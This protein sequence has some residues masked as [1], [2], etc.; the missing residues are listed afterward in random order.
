[1]LATIGRLYMGLIKGLAALA[2][3]LILFSVGLV[4]FSVI[5]RY[6]QLGGVQ[7]T[8]ATVEYILLY[9]TMFSA[10]YLLHTQGHVMVDMVVKNLRGFPRRALE[11]AIYIIG[12][13]VCSTFAVVSVQIMRQAIERGYFDERSVD[14][15]Y[16]LLYAAYPLCFGLL[17]IEFIR[18]LVTSRSLY[19]STEKNEGL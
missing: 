2:A 10:P 19:E 12:I 3:L 18:Y 17:T 15:P 11:S 16:W 4:V 7:A 5:W 14:V 13:I 8:I 6:L 9:F 1:M